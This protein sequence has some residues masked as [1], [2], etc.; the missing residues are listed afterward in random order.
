MPELHKGLGL[1][2]KLFALV[3]GMTLGIVAVSLVAG[4]GMQR[5]VGLEDDL[6][7]KACSPSS[8]RCS[9]IS[10]SSSCAAMSTSCW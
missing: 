7:K 1:R 8:A 6:H 2:T 5:L 9:S 3:A 4:I 10:S